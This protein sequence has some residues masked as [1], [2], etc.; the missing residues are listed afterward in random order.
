MKFSGQKFF[1]LLGVF[2]IPILFVGALLREPVVNRGLLRM[3]LSILKKRVGTSLKAQ[4]WKV[5]L[6]KFAVAVEGIEFKHEKIVVTAKELRAEFSPLF[7]L[8]GKVYLTKVWANEVLVSGHVDMPETEEKPF[9]LENDLN[10][11]ADHMI[12]IQ[13]LMDE[14][15]IGFELFQLSSLKVDT[16]LMKVKTVDFTIENY[17]RGHVKAEFVAEKILGTKRIP[18]IEKLQASAVLFKDRNSAFLSIRHLDA[19]L[20]NKELLHTTL[21]LKGRLPGDVSVDFVSDLSELRKWMSAQS[22]TKLSDLAQKNKFGGYFE[23]RGGGQLLGAGLKSAEVRTKGN[24]LV[25]NDF[26]LA[27]LESTLDVKEKDWKITKLTGSF[28]P[29]RLDPKAK[30]EFSG[31]DLIFTKERVSGE[32]EL[33]RM[34]LCALLRGVDVPDCQVDLVVNGKVQLAGTL[35]PFKLR[36]SVSLH[37]EAFEAYT[38]ADIVKKSERIDQPASGRL[39]KAKPAHVT[40][41]LDIR[42]GEMDLIDVQA[43]FSDATKIEARGNI[44]FHPARLFLRIASEQAKLE[45]MVSDFLTISTKGLLKAEV[46]VDYDIRRLKEFGKTDFFAD[47][48]IRGFEVGGLPLGDASGKLHFLK[49]ILEFKPTLRMGP[50]TL[51]VAGQIGRLDP[52]LNESQM[53]IYAEANEYEVLVPSSQGA[54]PIFDAVF[55][56]ESHLTGSLAAQSVRPFGGK[57][58]A[59]AHSLMSFGIPFDK[60]DLNAYVDLNGIK[61]EKLNAYK[62]DVR[63][64]LTGFL[65]PKNSRI[66]FSSDFVP[67]RQVGYIPEFERL[68]QG[69]ELKASGW[70]DQNKGWLVQAQSKALKIGANT[71]PTVNLRFEGDKDDGFFANIDS[72]DEIKIR[73]DSVEES[74][75]GKIKDSGIFLSLILINKWERVPEFLKVQGDIDVA[76]GKRTGQIDIKSLDFQ[77][78]DRWSQEDRQLI[79]LEAPAKIIYQDESFRGNADFSSGYG[80][81]QVKALGGDLSASGKLSVRLFDLFLPDFI[82]L[83][84]G[85]ADLDV[86][87]TPKSKIIKAKA[88]LEKTTAYLPSLGTELRGVNGKLRF[89]ANRIYFEEIQGR[90]GESGDFVLRGDMSSDANALNLNTRLN[91]VS[92]RIGRD[93]ELLVSGD[94]DLVGNKKPF[95]IRGK[96]RVDKGLLRK[97]FSGS[98]ISTAILEKP[99]I[100]FDIPFEIISSFQVKNSLADAFVTGRGRLSGTD[101]A[102]IISGRFDVTKGMLLAKDNEFTVNFA[103]VELPPDPDF[104]PMNVNVQAS[105]LKN[106]QG[107]D[108]RIFLS[109][110]GDPN[111]LKLNFRSEPSLAQKELIALL[112]LG[113]VPQEQVA[114]GSQGATIAQSASAEAFQLLFGQALG[115]GIQKQTGFDVR[116]GTSANLKQ[117]DTIPKVSVYRKLSDRVSATFGRSL[118]VSRP[119][120]NFKIDYRLLRNLNLTGVWEN[121]EENR[122]S[123]GLDLRLEFEIK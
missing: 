93:V 27:K 95:L 32:L 86:R 16:N 58:I 101:L 94:F 20:Q 19:E 97:D 120:N 40:G 43:E 110:E 9:H 21:E 47:Y 6:S 60:G 104:S 37:T 118:D 22:V 108:Y 63:T 2:L 84:D 13:E 62:G 116:V 119:E 72:G 79:K 54:A 115:K 38:D 113:Y 80:P 122:H 105:T 49:K 117:Q 46:S 52:N 36:P 48:L 82:R 15:K 99:M 5:D 68:A 107:I 71:Y 45:D 67:I 50:G 90:S 11:A 70:W 29:T 85:G 114:G 12:K 78:T 33:N 74:F 55:N 24:S 8:I 83:V 77:V 123:L 23:V 76:W 34:G 88:S 25:W 91:L 66:D 103:R 87:W 98:G 81:F 1:I 28:H 100:S 65:G 121:P 112:T 26:S 3:T 92:M 106:Y 64:E 96:A 111:N 75:I 44:K 61:I 69:G 89:E 102:P 59:S 51:K 30:N 39:L 41:S 53:S 7:L 10:A 73:Y 57:I 4:T 35:S 42:D 31:R 14:K 56:F 109:A 17:G 18:A